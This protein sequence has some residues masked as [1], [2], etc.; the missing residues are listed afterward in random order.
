M[1][2]ISRLPRRLTQLYSDTKASCDAVVDQDTPSAQ[3]EVSA[4]HRKFRIQKDRL[5]AWGMDWSDNTQEKQGDIAESV[6]RAGLTETVTSVLGTIKDILDEAEGMHPP[7][8]PA[9]AKTVSGEKSGR[10]PASDVP[11]WA[12]SDRS[13]YEDLAKDLTTSI[14]IL[15]NLSRTR[16]TQRGGTRGLSPATKSVPEPIKP[17]TAASV[18]LSSDY[19]ASDVTLINPAT[20]PPIASVPNTPSRPDLPPKLDPSDLILPEEE[21]PPYESVGKSSIRVIGKL[22]SR[23]SSTNPWKTDSGKSIETPVLVEYATY[24]STYR[25]TEV[26]PPTDRLEG[27]LAILAKLSNEQSFHGTLACK[28]YFEDPKQPR[29][30][31]VFELPSSV[32]SSAADLNKTPE[33]LRPVTLLNV[34]STGSKSLHNS[35][36]ATPPLEDRF[37]LA[38][39]L[40][41]TFSKIHGDS[42]VHKD[43]NSSNIL[44]FRKNKRLSPNSRAL[45]YSLRSPVICSFDL[46]SEYDIEPS[47]TMPTTLNIYRHPEDPRFTGDKSKPYGPQFD[48]YS[49]ALILLE[50][51]LWQPLS[52]LWKPKYTL[53][54]FKQRVEDVYIRRLASKCGTAYMQAVRDCFW[55][56]DR[57]ASGAE[58]FQQLYNRILI[59]LQRCCLLDEVDPS[60]EYGELGAATTAAAGSTQP[61]RKSTLPGQAAEM[62]PTSP[63]YKNAKRWAIEKG[64]QALERT[65]SLSKPSPT[66]TSLSRGSSQR[67]QASSIRH[68]ISHS[69]HLT[70]SREEM[71]RTI[72]WQERDP[73]EESGT[74]IATPPDSQDRGDASSLYKERMS[75]AASVIQRAWRASRESSGSK[76]RSPSL[77]DYKDRII[78]LQ[79]QW[80]Q[81][82]DVHGN[83]IS[84]LGGHSI[85][86]LGT[87]A[88]TALPSTGI[89]KLSPKLSPKSEQKAFE[90]KMRSGDPAGSHSNQP[91]WHTDNYIT[92]SIQIQTP[93]DPPARPKMRLHPIK[94]NDEITREWHQIMLPRLERLIERVLKDSDETVSIDLVAIGETEVKARPTILVTCTS[95]ARVRSIL[96]KKFKFDS[97]TYDL[98]VRNGKVRRSKMNRSN[99]RGKLPHRSMMNT[100]NFH[101]DMSVMNPFHQQRPVCGASIGAFRGEHLPPVSYGGVILVDDEP[102]GMSVHHLLDAPSDDESDAGDDYGRNDVTLSSAARGNSDWL[103]GMGSQPGVQIS[104]TSQVGM[105]DLEISDDE[106]QSD[107]DDEDDQESFNWDESEFDSDADESDD[108]L[109]DSQSSRTTIGDIDGIDVG[110]GEEI[111]ITQPAIDDV[112]EDFFP[113][114]ED[115]D[116]DHLSSHELGYVHASSGI[117]RWKRGG[118]LHEIDWA[119]LKLNEDRLQPYNLVQGGRRFCFK[120]EMEQDQLDISTKLEHPITRN[121]YKREEDEYPNGVAKADSLAGLNVHCF[122]RTTGLQ[123][124][125]VGSAMSSVRIYRRKTFSRSWHVAGGFGVGGDSGA[126]VVQ[127]SSHAVVG[128]VLAWCE[129]NH[130]AYICP[131]EVLLEDIKRTLGAKRIYLPGSSEENILPKSFE[132]IVDAQVKAKM[133][134]PIGFDEPPNE[135]FLAFMD[136]LLSYGDHY[137]NSAWNPPI[138]PHDEAKKKYHIA[139]YNLQPMSSR[140]FKYCQMIHGALHHCGMGVNGGFKRFCELHQ[141]RGFMS[142]KIMAALIIKDDIRASNYI[143]FETVDLSTLPDYPNTFFEI[144]KEYT[145][146]AKRYLDNEGT[147]AAME[148]VDHRISHTVSAEKAS[149]DKLWE[150]R[151]EKNLLE[152]RDKYQELLVDGSLKEALKNQASLRAWLFDCLLT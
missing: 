14:D 85:T 47:S 5:I 137:W 19:N 17:P 131:M 51:G 112:D 6:E 81:R 20:L 134:T 7:A 108:D 40:S 128:H 144:A 139:S 87:N 34:L 74:L 2:T 123:G 111:R 9:G 110:Y 106:M 55:A 94:F 39:T 61:K 44:V 126:W 147:P 23:H 24:D 140:E 32:Y 141:E 151:R 45:H 121:Y 107:F 77:K 25:F 105:W 1:E 92:S 54:D 82:K 104:P 28:G 119:L 68:S 116:D 53:S 150:L 21:P 129:R 80:R 114:A 73:L 83:V 149:Q 146:I 97:E 91:S 76:Q 84:A 152:I 95:T 59:R 135:Y 49:L 66:H 26:S 132:L 65:R 101:G 16:K 57:I 122:G 69:L 100:N 130:I 120:Q 75:H 90:A 8:S 15:Y 99:R 70:G 43:V 136:E 41:L 64:T 93:V 88:I 52:D 60:F 46:F 115:R 63:S 35:N 33:E 113:S 118:I 143:E 4:L 62:P 89:H 36:S 10:Q 71:P 56:A 125:M 42:F 30:G 22:R 133:F 3:P 31:L 148:D 102:L 117:R 103:M 124:G 96:N 86:A 78:F 145:R 67:S 138:T 142:H 79:K 12:A 11:S 38:F 37:R 27:L 109:V 72:E 127:N 50:V 48:L 13:R 18:F 98:K 58:D 29:F